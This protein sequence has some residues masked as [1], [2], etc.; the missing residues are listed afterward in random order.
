LRWSPDGRAVQF[1][2]TKGYVTNIWEQLL[3]GG[4]PRQITNFTSGSIVDFNW[5]PEGKH[6]LMSRGE[7]SS[8]VVLLSNIR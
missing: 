6:L 2:L 1:L 7:I 5:Y 3:A 4:S 8:D